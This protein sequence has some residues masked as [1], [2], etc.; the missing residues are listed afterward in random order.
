MNCNL[1][2]DVDLWNYNATVDSALPLSIKQI[3]IFRL[4]Q[5]EIFWKLDGPETS[6]IIS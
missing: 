1:M 3:P 2:R 6:E 5:N 4:N